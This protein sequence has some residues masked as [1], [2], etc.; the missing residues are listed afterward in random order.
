MKYIG[1][2]TRHISPGEPII[3]PFDIDTDEKCWGCDSGAI[4]NKKLGLCYVCSYS[5]VGRC[6]NR[7]KPNYI[8]RFQ[9]KV[10]NVV[11]TYGYDVYLS[12]TVKDIKRGQLTELSKE[13]NI[14]REYMR[15][16][17]AKLRPLWGSSE[18]DLISFYKRARETLNRGEQI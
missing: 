9:R 5:S 12:L 11:E 4:Y 14:T 10:I 2:A 1:T 7:E 3:S 6:K 17:R 16:I 13:Y 18:K 8:T 15:Q